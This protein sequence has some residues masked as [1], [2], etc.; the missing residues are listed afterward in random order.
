MAQFLLT[1]YKWKERDIS[2]QSLWVDDQCSPPKFLPCTFVGE[3]EGRCGI[4]GMC[5]MVQSMED[6]VHS[7]LIIWSQI[8]GI[9]SIKSW[10]LR[11]RKYI[12]A[13]VRLSSF[14]SI[15]QKWLWG[16]IWA[17]NGCFNGGEC[18]LWTIEMTWDLVGSPLCS[19]FNDQFFSLYMGCFLCQCKIKVVI[20]FRFFCRHWTQFTIK[21]PVI[22]LHTI[23]LEVELQSQ[24]MPVATG[25]SN[26]FRLVVQYI[27]ILTNYNHSDI[28]NIFDRFSRY[29]FRKGFAK[30]NAIL[31]EWKRSNRCLSSNSSLWNYEH[32]SFCPLKMF[33]FLVCQTLDRNFTLHLCCQ[34][35]GRTA[36]KFLQSNMW[37][38]N[39]CF[40][41]T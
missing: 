12:H 7:E 40:Y 9:L 26:C 17:R 38:R 41:C 31:I 15:S 32:F 29:L 35:L 8:C 20:G 22:D 1:I 4:L 30:N 11:N 34:N 33:H 36:Q 24:C 23:D 18:R 37:P 14:N 2:E 16:K 21:Q 10:I 5:S 27:Y 3:G 28:L 19:L 13:T 39:C 6:L 25:A